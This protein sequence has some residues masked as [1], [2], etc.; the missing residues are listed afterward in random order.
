[1]LCSRGNINLSRQERIPQ[2]RIGD[3][4]GKGRDSMYQEREFGGY[5][6]LE[7][8]YGGEYFSGRYEVRRLNSGRSAIYQAYQDSGAER[9][10]LPVYLCPSVCEFLK[11]KNVHMDFYNIGL[12]FLPEKASIGKSDILLWVNYFGIQGL[13]QIQEINR[14]YENVIFDNTQ[15]FFSPV[16]ENSYN[17]FSCRKFFGV[18]DG[19]YLIKRKFQKCEERIEPSQTLETAGYL[20]ESID[21]STN[22]CY[23]KSLENEHRL[24]RE[25]V[26][27]MSR[28]TRKI[29]G[30]IDY[31]EDAQ[32]RIINFKSLCEY[33]GKYNQLN[34]NMTDH[35]PMVYPFLVENKELR[36]YLVQNKI[37]VPQW[38]KVVVQN[39]KA[40]G[41]ERYLAEYLIPLPIDQRYTKED[42]ML[43]KDIVI[44][45]LK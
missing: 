25:D 16:Q 44:G 8:P 26:M 14:R 31:K 9:V 19:A 4:N 40:N 38:W 22:D 29:L 35:A 41:W 5:F 28:I 32:R 17:V 42:M 13:S 45:G 34:I 24:E 20:W 11:R 3:K 37:Y 23:I 7:L 43:M 30:G 1:M 33:L 10:W 21:K 12:D 6:S 2:I 36:S 15:A 18:S 39:K 27:G